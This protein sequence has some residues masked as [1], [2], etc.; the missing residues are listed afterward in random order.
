MGIKVSSTHKHTSKQMVKL[1]IQLSV[2]LKLFIG[3]YN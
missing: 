3:K 2:S 1:N